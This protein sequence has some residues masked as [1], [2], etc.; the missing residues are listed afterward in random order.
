MQELWGVASFC[1][2]DSTVVSLW[3]ACPSIQCFVLI[4]FTC[5][6]F[7]FFHFSLYS[8][9]YA[10]YQC[11]SVHVMLVFIFFY[12]ILPVFPPLFSPLLFSKER[13]IAQASISSVLTC[14]LWIS[15]NRPNNF[16]QV[17]SFLPFDCTVQEEGLVSSYGLS[18]WLWQTM[19]LSCD[20]LL[21]PPDLSPPVL[22]S[23]VTCWKINVINLSSQCAGTLLVMRT[24]NLSMQ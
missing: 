24:W 21:K 11:T 1:N 2:H 23:Q 4:C 9:L 13:R 19:R 7:T 10:R 14:F 20:W 6:F 5:F 18:H 8:L 16:N 22:A 12:F 17:V 15:V 3:D